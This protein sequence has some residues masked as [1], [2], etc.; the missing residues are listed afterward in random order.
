[1]CVCVCVCVCVERERERE[2]EITGREKVMMKVSHED[3]VHERCVRTTSF[4]DLILLA[5]R[6]IGHAVWQ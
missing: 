4:L 3:A 1:V 2:R 6:V 5:K